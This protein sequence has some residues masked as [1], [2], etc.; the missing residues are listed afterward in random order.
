VLLQID[1]NEPE[2]WLLARAADI[3]RRGGVA[4]IPTDT[5]YGLACALSAEKAIQ[6]IYALKNL[7]P[8]K[9][10]AILV[11]DMATVNRYARGISTPTYRTMKRVLPGPYTFIFEATRETP[12]IMLRKRKTIGIRWPDN[13]IVLSLLAKLDEPLLTTSIRTP[14]DLFVNDPIEIEV[15]F[16]HR[17][18]LVIDGG[19]LLPQPSTVVDF[20]GDEPVLLRAGKGDVD[21]LQL[22]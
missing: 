2:P 20:S 11:N 12:K 22:T 10:L 13:A 8:K 21:A 9:P 1:P 4:V 7:D 16:A 19:V 15:Q 3:L 17:V 18:D 14:E 5:V 6:R